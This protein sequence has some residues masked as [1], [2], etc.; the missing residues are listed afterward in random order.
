MSA[1][2]PL[3]CVEAV[4]ADGRVTVRFL[5]GGGR[6]EITGDGAELETLSAILSHLARA[7]DREPLVE[8]SAHL[9]ATLT[10]RPPPRKS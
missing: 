8:S 3:L 1:A 4:V 7:G 2:P 10:L 5:Q 6:A 9:R